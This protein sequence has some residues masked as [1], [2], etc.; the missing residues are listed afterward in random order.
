MR[1]QQLGLAALTRGQMGAMR[2]GLR[3]HSAVGLMLNPPWSH[4]VKAPP[5][6]RVMEGDGAFG[7]SGPGSCQCSSSGH[8]QM[9]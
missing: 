7:A 6:V 1:T 4:C 8:L 3:R 5:G 2:S 9:S